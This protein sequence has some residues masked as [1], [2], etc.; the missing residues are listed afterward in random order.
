ML[1]ARCLLP[2]SSSFAKKREA[3]ADNSQPTHRGESEGSKAQARRGSAKRQSECCG[4]SR[5]GR[6]PVYS[7]KLLPIVRGMASDG[8]TDFEIASRL[9]VS[10][11]T[12]RWWRWEHIEFSNAMR[13]G[14]DA[15]VERANAS[16][17][18]RAVGYSFRSEK[19]FQSQ[20][21]IIRAPIIEHIPPDVTAAKM[22][23]QAYDT[24]D[25][26]R[27]KRDVKS[28]STFSL[29]DLIAMSWGN[30]RPSAPPRPRASWTRAT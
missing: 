6:K 18:H 12:L 29:A 19:V 30:A 25:V 23:L 11:E 22:I 20:G 21:A 7:G 13:V 28:E 3:S 15:M 5:R 8:A 27:D 10:K 24:E 16:L 4:Q 9:G 26:W 17:F 2:G 1:I 14:R